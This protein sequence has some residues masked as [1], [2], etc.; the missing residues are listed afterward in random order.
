MDA[1]PAPMTIDQRRAIFR[2]LVEHQDGGETV[3][4]SRDL[5]A[6]EFTVTEEQ[7]RAIEREGSDNDWPPLV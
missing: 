4:S 1:T 7:V 3:A 2:A 5:T 6:K